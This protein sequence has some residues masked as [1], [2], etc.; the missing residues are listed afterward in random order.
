MVWPVID[1]RPVK[2]SISTYVLSVLKLKDDDN[3]AA[4]LQYTRACSFS[5][6]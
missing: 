1:P 6:N 3:V 4:F 2:G 5:G